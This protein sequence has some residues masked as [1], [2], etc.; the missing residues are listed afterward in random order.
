MAKSKARKAAKPAAKKKWT[1]SGAVSIPFLFRFIEAGPWISAAAWDDSRKRSAGI[2]LS[3]T[4]S[5]S[6]RR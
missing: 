2:S 4:A 6:L 3:A 5:I 1:V